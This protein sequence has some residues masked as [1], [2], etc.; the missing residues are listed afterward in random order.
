M[1]N[2]LW[3]ILSFEP[4]AFRGKKNKERKNFLFL[5]SVFTVPFSGLKAI[6]KYKAN[7]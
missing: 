3:F 7:N 2:L 5:N 1:S 4:L 6:D